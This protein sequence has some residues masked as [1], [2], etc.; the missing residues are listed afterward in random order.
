MKK[1]YINTRG[2]DNKYIIYNYTVLAKS[3]T[4]KSPLYRGGDIECI[5][6]YEGVDETQNNKLLFTISL[7]NSDESSLKFLI[8]EGI[9]ELP[10]HMLYIATEV[11]QNFKNH[12][13]ELNK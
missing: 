11:S 10:L 13:T 5:H 8:A 6:V 4:H 7:E 1:L 3:S 12:Y 2:I 9:K